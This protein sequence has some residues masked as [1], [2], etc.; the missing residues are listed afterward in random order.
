MA[1]PSN[2]LKANPRIPGRRCTF[3]PEF[4]PSLQNAQITLVG[5][6]LMGGSLAL[7]LKSARLCRSVGALVR[8]EAA[9]VEAQQAGAV[10]WAT[11]DPA[12][13]LKDA[14]LVVFSTPVRI[15]ITQLKNYAP[16]FKPGAVITDM[17]STKRE[18]LAALAQL[19]P[20]VFPLGSHPMCGKE[21]SGLAA[22]VP[23]LYQNATWVLSPL[24]QTP[25]QALAL[26][27]ALAE[28]VG[29]KPLVLE[30]GRHDKLAATI[31]H[32][33]YLLATALVL[34]AQEVARE[35]EAVWQVAATGFKDTSRLAA[36]SV[37]MMQDILLTNPV[38]VA[39]MLKRV[40][41]QLGALEEKILA[42][43]EAELQAVL[44]QAQQQRRALF[45]SP[46]QKSAG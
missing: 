25:P 24:P 1:E 37:Q 9:A 14:D 33:P 7:R 21:V 44:T 43:D 18:I 3:D 5:L 10:D 17:G 46:M 38:E 23:G 16:F 31:S 30:A 8:R 6:G 13:A 2:Q 42:G 29:A 26:V 28:A 41:G 20:Q 39:A 45:V 4:I 19:P 22:A 12:L 34:A 36:S 15:L 27:R 11:T 40:C 32:V 35:D